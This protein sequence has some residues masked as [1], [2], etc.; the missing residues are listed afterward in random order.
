MLKRL[1][2]ETALYGG[3]TILV[4]LINYALVPLHT[5][6]FQSDSYGIVSEFYAWATVFNVIYSYGME[7][8]YFRFATKKGGNPQELFNQIL[9]LLI[10][11]SVCLSGFLI[12]FS[13]EIA[14][15]MGYPNGQQF[16]TWFALLFAIDA[17][18]A[19]PFAQLRILHK[20][21]RFAV[22]KILSIVAVFLL[23]L[24]FLIA[25]RDIYAG[26]YLVGLQP[27]IN[28]F[29]DPQ[30]GLGYAF[31]ANLL[32]NASLLL[33]LWPS[34]KK[35]RFTLNF[36]AVKPA[37]LYGYPILFSGLAFAVN[38]AADR[39]FL[40]Y[41][42]PQGLYPELSNLDVVGIYAAC[43]KLS[44]FIT[45]GVQAF[46]YAAE[47]FFFS[48]AN[49][50][51]SK[52]AY[53]LIMKYFIVITSLMFLGVTANM[54]WLAWI[55]LQQETYH[56]GLGVVPILLLANIFLGIY[57]NLSVWFKVTDRTRYGAYIS[58]GGATITVLGN[59]LL[60]PILGY[61]GSAWATLLC[62][63]SMATASYLIGKRFY[64]IP[65]QLGHAMAYLGLSVLV[66]FALVTSAWPSGW[67]GIFL[68][69]A[70]VAVIYLPLLWREYKKIKPNVVT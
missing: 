29:Y 3:T 25:C 54:N 42:L 63:G 45:L 43:Y 69:N 58:L 61:F 46:K 41:L 7:T 34:F 24:F 19:I 67:S 48:K 6:V 39:I 27:L 52:D 5:G 33:I 36:A 8:A 22:A 47:P 15:L 14:Y 21:K 16:V 68:K 23:N 40:K 12:L 31:L 60:I 66:A 51:D 57:Y 38:E 17:I 9:S 70:L 32:G 56:Q 53:A 65:Y 59:L 30:M 4:R 1:A 26:K 44:V 55:F 10:V 2:S 49:D 64:A 50:A 20:A 37:F 62:Y 13:G 28:T 11:T 18:V 35:L